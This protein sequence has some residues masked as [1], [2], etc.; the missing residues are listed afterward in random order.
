MT[1]VTTLPA[2]SVANV[3]N[4]AAAGRVASLALT[5]PRGVPGLIGLGGLLLLVAVLAHLAVRRG[6]GWRAA[7]RRLRREAAATAAAFAAPVRAQLRFC[8]GL[9]LILRLLGD[10]AGWADAERAVLGAGLVPGVRPYGALLGPALVGVLVACGPGT[11]PGPPEPWVVDDADPRLWWITR[12]EVA[13]TPVGGGRPAPLLALL[14]TDGRHA[15]L[16]DLAD[17]PAVTEFG[18][19][20]GL[21]RAV[22]QAVAAQLDTRLPVGAVTVADGVHPHH[23]GPEAAAALLAAERAAAGGH[24]AFAV[25]ATV[26][27]EERPAVGVRVL[28]L[29]GSR[30]SAR[31]LTADRDG[32]RIRGGGLR[33]DAVA[34]PRAT[35]RILRGLPPHPAFD[36][37]PADDTDLVEPDLTGPTPPTPPGEPGPGEPTT[38]TTVT[39]TTVT[40]PTG[41]APFPVGPKSGPTAPAP[42]PVVP[43]HP[44]P[45]AAPTPPPASVDPL[46]PKPPVAV[47]PAAVAPEP[48]PFR[49]GPVPPAPDRGD[50]VPAGR[51]RFARR[52]PGTDEAAS[53]AAT[54]TPDWPGAADPVVPG[55][56]SRLGRLSP[57]AG[58]DEGA[59]GP[60]RAPAAG[61]PGA[62]P[63]E[64]DLAEPD[65]AGYG[66]GVSAA[67]AD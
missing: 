54:P 19:E 13:A 45:A 7:R 1:T 35:A 32:L 58:P 44:A 30:G 67:V 22:L 64:D 48:V 15:V 59:F 21:A 29:G 39:G 4:A 41:P 56:R 9:R 16:L 49:V 18:G 34:L 50:P 23:P 28:T 62:P 12:E 43:G 31:L 10:R 11:P 33:V 42:G 66:P 5:V 60:V 24:P 51:Q 52:S 63:E 55:V 36:A 2:E 27:D 37:A 61:R 65:R 3:A 6:G 14:G 20:R 25:C 26:V 17:G 38:G 53:A 47:D 46:R 57:V 8:R 40:A